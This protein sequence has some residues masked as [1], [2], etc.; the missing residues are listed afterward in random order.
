MFPIVRTID[1]IQPSVAHV[2]EIKFHRQPN[3]VTVGCYMFMDDETFSSP[4]SLECRGIAFDEAGLVVSRPLHKFFNLG[5]KSW[6]SVDRLR[7]RKVARVMEKLDGSMIATAWVEGKL[8]WRSK[9]AFSS[10]VV[11]LTEDFLAKPENGNLVEFAVEIARNG[12]TAIFELTHPEA[13]IVVKHAKP[14]LRLLHV[15]D[16]LTGEYV[17]LDEAHEVHTLVNTHAIPHVDA[18][19]LSLDEILDKLSDM[20]DQEGYVVQFADGDMVKIKCPWYLRLHRSITFLRERDIAALSLTEEL[21]D[22]KAALVEAGIALDAVNE[23][24]HRLKTRLL[25]LEDEVED[26]V[27]AGNGLDRKG[28]ALK[29]KEHPLFG[30]AMQRYL[31]KEADISGWYAKNKLRQEFGLRVLAEGAQAEAMEG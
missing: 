7:H 19:N 23:V 29:H 20:R 25:S 21:D 22:V 1:D 3:N 24:E 14:E 5:E 30:L 9:K 27:T 18:A 4:E 13:R 6:L 10:D 15:R 26:M 16:N 2:S 28:F 8:A 31:G 12:M 11:K 17:L